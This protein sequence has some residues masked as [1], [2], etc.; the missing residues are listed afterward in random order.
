MRHCDIRTGPYFLLNK[1]RRKSGKEVHLYLIK[2]VQH[3]NATQNFHRNHKL[4]ILQ[5][6]NINFHKLLK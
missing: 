2:K 5:N 4:I 1:K 6:E 3:V